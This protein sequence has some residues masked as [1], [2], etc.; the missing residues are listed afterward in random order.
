MTVGQESCEG[1]G[2]QSCE[3]AE[4]TGPA[5]AALPGQSCSLRVHRNLGQLRG[6]S[7]RCQTP[8]VA[9]SQHQAKLLV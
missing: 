1:W 6:E 5:R 8:E 3:V 9:L 2:K 4:D 7:H